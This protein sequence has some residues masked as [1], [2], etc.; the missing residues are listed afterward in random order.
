MSIIYYT[1]VKICHYL[2]NKKNV[3]Q[4]RETFFDNYS[5]NIIY[6]FSLKKV[7]YLDHPIEI[8]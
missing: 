7:E 8:P 1:R 6:F 2:I 5:K 4:F 3:S